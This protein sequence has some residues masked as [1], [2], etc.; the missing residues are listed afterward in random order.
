MADSNM[1]PHSGIG[2][3]TP[4]SYVLGPGGAWLE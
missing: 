2:A 1:V 4:V 3:T